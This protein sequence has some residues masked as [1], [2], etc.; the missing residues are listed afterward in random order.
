MSYGSNKVTN[1]DRVITPQKEKEQTVQVKPTVVKTSTIWAKMTQAEAVTNKVID[2]FKQ[3]DKNNNGTIDDDE[4]NKYI[5]Q[6]NTEDKKSNTD[7]NKSVRFDINNLFN[8]P[9]IK[10]NQYMKA[11]FGIENFDS[12]S[13]A[14]KEKAISEAFNK[15]YELNGEDKNSNYNKNLDRLK[16]GQYTDFEKEKLGFKAGDKLSEEDIKKYAKG[17]NNAER[18]KE[19]SNLLINVDNPEDKKLFFSS[20]EN[21]S[22]DAKDSLENAVGYF[23]TKMNATNKQEFINKAKSAGVNIT[24]DKEEKITQSE[25]D[26]AELKEASEEYGFDFD[27]LSKEGPIDLEKF[28]KE[29][30]NLD[31]SKMATDDEK[32]QAIAKKLDEKFMV[33]SKKYKDNILRLKKRQFTTYELKKLG[34]GKKRLSNE[35]IKKYAEQSLD[36][37][38]LYT[39]AKL[40]T[41]T[42]DEKSKNIIYNSIA[43][44]DG[45]TQ[46]KI[47]RF[48]LASIKDPD[49]QK[50]FVKS[51]SHSKLDYKGMTNQNVYKTSKAMA[52]A[53]YE[54]SIDIAANATGNREQTSAST[55]GI[56]EANKEQLKNGNETQEEYNENYHDIAEKAHEFKSYASEV[57]NVVQSNASD[58]NRADTMSTLGS[59]VYQIQD[60]NERS[61]AL[62]GL[63]TSKY[64]NEDV[65]KSINES[66][67]ISTTPE[68]NKTE[69]KSEAPAPQTTASN[70]V[71]N[72]SNIPQQTR[73]VTELKEQAK[74]Y[75][76]ESKVTNPINNINEEH[77][78]KAISSSI[79][80]ADENGVTQ[81]E[82][83]IRSKKVSEMLDYCFRNGTPSKKIEQI[84]FNKL[85][86][87]S[88]PLIY[89]VF[90]NCN[91]KVKKYIFDTRLMTPATLVNYL[92]SDD[93]KKIPDEIKTAVEK[94]KE[95]NKLAKKPDDKKD[96]A[97]A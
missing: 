16:N 1:N 41:N 61:Q 51:I 93:M 90:I 40:M 94:Y 65:A 50:A 70:N 12:L 34:L 26:N 80:D 89:N 96:E 15:K 46:A 29:S 22:G 59:H 63:T 13:N 92:R 30:L 69:T 9:Q 68:A 11:Q 52:S 7:N 20:L 28:S 48:A 82:K 57:Y 2:I 6:S 44:Q 10:L 62:N 23:M 45:R 25:V 54:V 71:D 97:V 85:S 77:E 75:E 39:E 78:T 79:K 37:Q 42:N 64:Y 5:E 53:N 88:V 84:I 72:T 95:D 49:K 21:M 27:G 91:A 35:A 87:A 3:Y 81:K 17:A 24:L 33:G 67:K 73:N 74:Q 86:A 38:K 47:V 18:L 60:E 66:Y 55:T 36:R 8:Q 56:I 76:T 32:S 14:D 4:Y 31:L 19:I 43:Y 83:A 58:D